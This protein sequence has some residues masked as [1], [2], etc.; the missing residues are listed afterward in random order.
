MVAGFW[1]TGRLLLIIKE[2]LYIPVPLIMFA[3]L[4]LHQLKLLQNNSQKYCYNESRIDLTRSHYELSEPQRL[5][6]NQVSVA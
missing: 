1:G 2:C 3:Y 5:T 6:F 4:S